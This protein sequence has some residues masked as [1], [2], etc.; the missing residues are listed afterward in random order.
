ML[1]EKCQSGDSQFMAETRFVDA[2]QQSRAK[3]PMHLDRA[4]DHLLGQR[5]VVY[6][7]FSVPL[8]LCASVVKIANRG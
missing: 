2:F 8:Y 3:G 4:T 1:L 6:H 7:V 5:I